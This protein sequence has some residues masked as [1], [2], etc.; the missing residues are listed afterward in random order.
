[1]IQPS[2][3]TIYRIKMY[4]DIL[5]L[6]LCAHPWVPQGIS[7]ISIWQAKGWATDFMSMWKGDALSFCLPFKQEH[8][9][10][11]VTQATEARVTWTSISNSKFSFEGGKKKKAL[12][13]WAYCCKSRATLWKHGHHQEITSMGATM[14]LRHLNPSLSKILLCNTTVRFQNSV[15]RIN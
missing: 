7:F 13:T 5:C 12:I 4:S 6:I 9:H 1:M 11:R 15:S 3:R 10:E 8:Q 2:K 14:M